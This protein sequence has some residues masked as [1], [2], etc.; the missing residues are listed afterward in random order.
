MSREGKASPAGLAFVILPAI[1]RRYAFK[2]FRLDSHTVICFRVKLSSEMHMCKEELMLKI[3]DFSKLSRISIRMLR[4][5]D[6]TGLLVPELVDDCTGYR[7]YSEKQLPRAGMIRAFKEFGFGLAV[8]GEIL[9]KYQDPARMEQFLAVKRKELEEEQIK[10]SEKLRLIDSALKWLG[11]D[12][13]IMDYSVTLKTMPE[14]YVASVRQVIPAYDRES[15]LWEIL[16]K[17]TASLNIQEASPCYGIA[18]FHDG[19]HKESDPDVEIQIAVTGRYRDTEHVKFKTV[20]EM[21]IASSTYKGSYE[22]ITGVNK[23][24]ANWIV[25]NGYDFAGKSFCI[26]HVSPAQTSDPE[27]LVTEVCFPVR[28]KEA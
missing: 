5:Y 21:Q 19:E 20:P 16:N 13:K 15:M 18:V 6:E 1:L 7:Y 23:A 11:K 10:L 8:I 25:E 24:V 28:R 12:G 14:R 17:E 4:Y 3:G 22:Q 26:Y 27:E 2:K 9:D